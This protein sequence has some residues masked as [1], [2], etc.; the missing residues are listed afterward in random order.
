MKRKLLAIIMVSIFAAC[1]SNPKATTQ[2]TTATT[3]DTSNFRN[4]ASADKG[5]VIELKGVSDTIVTGD[6]NRYVKVDPNKATV[7]AQNNIASTV[8]SPS[9]KAPTAT[10][11]HSS[12]R[13]TTHSSGHHHSSGGYSGNGTSGGGYSGSGTQNAPVA[14]RKKG[15][16]KAAKDAAIGAGVGAVGGAIISK[17]KGLGAVIGGVVGGAGGYII[18]RNKDKKD[19]RY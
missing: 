11:H 3:V 15:W 4:N 10:T 2:T 13:T 6:G 9:V 1:N 8:P 12:S 16:S 5:Q 18:G 17:K 19:G 7:P 14:T